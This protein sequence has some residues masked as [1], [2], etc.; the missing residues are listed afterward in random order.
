MSTRIYDGAFIAQYE[1]DSEL[2]KKLTDDIWEFRTRYNGMAFRLFV[3][4][5]EEKNAMVVAYR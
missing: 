4:W 5:D 1:N 3:F 2:F